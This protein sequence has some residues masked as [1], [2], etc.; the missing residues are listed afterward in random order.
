MNPKNTLLLIMALATAV[1]FANIG[2]LD[3]YA[4][5]EAKNAEAAREMLESGNY[6]VP[7]FNYELRTDK[8]PL[9][10][11]FMVAGYQLFGV[12]AFG[13]RF[14]SSLAG[15]LTILIV[16]LF[17]LR[18]LGAKTAIYTALGLICSLHFAF[19]VR[20]SVP[21][22]YLIFFL[23]WGFTSFYEAWK[24]GNRWQ[25]LIFYFSIGCGLLVKGP[26]ALGLAGF[27]ALL[28][29][30][31]KRDLKW[32]TIWRLQPF[33]GVLLSLLLA[34]PWYWQV[35]VQTDGFW[36]SEFFFKHNFS[37]FSEPM[38][39]HKG[40]FLLTFAYVFV[41]GMLTFLPFVFQSIKQ[42]VKQRKQADAL[43]Y[44][45]TAAGVIIGFFAISSTKL[46]NYTVPS[47]P[48]LAVILGHYLAKIG[49]EW[50]NN[51]WN[52]AGLVAY[53]VFLILFPFGIRLGL[54]A[55]KDLREIVHL[56]HY[57][58]PVF[59]TGLV[60]LVYVARKSLRKVILLIM[61][62]W[63][64]TI[65]LFFHVIYPQADH[66]NPVR[67]TLPT[68]DTSA[69]IIGFK[70]FNPAFVFALKR[71]VSCADKLEEVRSIVAAHQSGYIISRTE[72]REELEKIPGVVYHT[73]ARDTF[74]EPVTLIM[75]WN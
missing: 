2:G 23:T 5:D 71:E 62:G 60:G 31:F 50:L 11:Y 22:P 69:K 26:V 24:T 15:V 53:L 54:G 66:I 18:N 48:V 33:G 73:E 21:D 38:E 25:L 61:G 40:I 1:C 16:Y 51:P 45:L 59:A 47:Y 14:F 70:K 49:D 20:M 35:H 4:L 36:T 28:F 3:I 43:L 65:V 68:M 72:Y 34:L 7:Y 9:H 8:P 13:A 55:D 37:R 46:P 17:A 52:K 42:A 32:N 39:G 67:Q 57:F 63:A 10:Y 64:I 27:T 44:C 75:K 19:Q 56:S 12:N 41:M 29:L 30:V 6:V 74:E 58:W